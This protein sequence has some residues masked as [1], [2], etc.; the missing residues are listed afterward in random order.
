MILKHAALPMLVVPFHR[1]DIP[2]GLFLRILKDGGF[3]EK[4]FLGG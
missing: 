2:R 4:N 1:G 3:T